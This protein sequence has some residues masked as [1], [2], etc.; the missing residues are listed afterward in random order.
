MTRIRMTHKGLALMTA[1]TMI[2]LLSLG[3]AAIMIMNVQHAEVTAGVIEYKVA[4]YLVQAAAA[5]ARERVKKGLGTGTYDIVAVGPPGEPP[6]INLF[7]QPNASRLGTVAIGAAGA[8]PFG[9]NVREIVVTI[10][11]DDPAVTTPF[12]FRRFL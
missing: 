8:S 3:G 2:L 6:D 10:S 5:V 11:P 12:E 7:V 4:Y 9:S 1:L